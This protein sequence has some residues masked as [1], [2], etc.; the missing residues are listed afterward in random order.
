MTKKFKK[1]IYYGVIIILFIF[2][3]R[4]VTI[5]PKNNINELNILKEENKILKEDINYL[6]NLNYD[7][8]YEICKISIKNLYSSNTYFINC[9]FKPNNNIVLNDIGFIGLVNDNK[10]TLSKDLILSI[11]IN[12]NK[13]IL[14]DNKINIIHDNYNIGDKIYVS[15]LNEE[16]LLGYI[17]NIINNSSYDIISIKYIDINSSYV[18][19][20]T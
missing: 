8:N 18:V 7:K 20:I 11:K 15:Y 1:I 5:V 6:S 19:V 16:Y 4:I 12:D 3:D 9:N 14:K 17:S 2:I 13:G 10:L